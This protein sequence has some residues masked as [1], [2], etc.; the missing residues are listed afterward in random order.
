MNGCDAAPAPAPSQIV[1]FHRSSLALSRAPG[2]T[3]S[4]KVR[5][6][7]EVTAGLTV[8]LIPATGVNVVVAA[9]HGTTTVSGTKV[10]DMPQRMKPLGNAPLR[11]LAD[12]GVVTPRGR[13]PSPMADLVIRRLPPDS[14]KTTHLSHHRAL[15]DR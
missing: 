3:Q 1:F 9:L 14:S 15:A 10:T 4:L 2:N 11:R 12:M 8:T 5:D 13:A 7:T 6:A